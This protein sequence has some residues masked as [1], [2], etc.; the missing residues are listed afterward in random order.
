MS[1]G[2]VGPSER[3]LDAS[4]PR[5]RDILI[6]G[7]P[8][9]GTTLAI[10]LL[11]KLDDTVALPEPMDIG[12]VMQHRDDRAAAHGEIRA[13]LAATRERILSEGVA[14]ARLVD[15][16]MTTNYFDDPDGTTA[17]RKPRVAAG[18][19]KIGKPLSKHFLLAIKHPAL[20]T[21]M[22]PGLADE[23]ET[24][25]VV[26]EPVATLCSWN[27]L[28]TEFRRGRASPA[29]AFAPALGDELA[30]IGDEIDRQIHLLS[31]YFAKLQTLPRERVIRYEDIVSSG[32]AALASIAPAA[33]SLAVAMP[34]Y[35]VD[36]RY[37]GINI[38]DIRSRVRC[39]GTAFEAYYPEL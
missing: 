19:L 34:H 5:G 27:T 20:F 26:R 13:F 25:A 36:Q 22:L 23:F 6:A 37:A 35:Q 8:R 15:G 7:P 4:A 28:N 31:F 12:R 30:S 10:W 1:I 9:A 3:Y 14:P 39:A 11:D 2:S 29:E 24:F 38:E 18:L 16:A 21:G 32:G 17:P 33:K